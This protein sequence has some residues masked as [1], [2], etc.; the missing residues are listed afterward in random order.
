MKQTILILSILF[1]VQCF[2][3]KWYLNNV[4]KNE[5]YPY[6][7]WFQFENVEDT[8]SYQ[9]TKKSESQVS[10]IR[11]MDNQEDTV[12]LANIKVINHRETIKSGLLKP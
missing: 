6:E 3:Q 1:S 10:N 11:L 9:L 4:D 5:E 7:Y 8:C 12:V 2:G